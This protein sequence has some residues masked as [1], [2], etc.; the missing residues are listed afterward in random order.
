MKTT[1]HDRG[2]RIARHLPSSSGELSSESVQHSRR[3][4]SPRLRRR[5]RRDPARDSSRWA[6]VVARDGTYFMFTPA[7]RE[8]VSWV[9]R[10]GSPLDRPRDGRYAS[11]AGMSGDGCIYAADEP[12]DVGRHRFRPPVRGHSCGTLAAGS[13]DGEA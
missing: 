12:D 7:W 4:F 10:V 13:F 8:A 11:R 2:S 1:R 3:D 9:K 6:R 5:H